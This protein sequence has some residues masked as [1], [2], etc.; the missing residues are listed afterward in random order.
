MADIS[1]TNLDSGGDSP[2]AARAQILEAVQRVNQLTGADGG[3]YVP[4][5]QAGTDAQVR[6]LLDK[7]RGAIL[8]LDDF[9]LSPAISETTALVKALAAAGVGG[10][11][12]GEVGRTYNIV[13]RVDIASRELRDVRLNLVGNSASL[14]LTGSA[15]LKH[16]VISVGSRSN[17]PLAVVLG[18]A[19]NL[20]LGNGIV[21]DDVEITDGGAGQIGI[22]C[23]TWANNTTI[24]NCRLNYIGWP[25]WFNDTSGYARVVDSINYDSVSLGKTLRVHN[26]ELGAADKTSRGDTL[27]VN[28]PA[29]RFADLEVIGC[30]S[31]KTVTLSPTDT[32]GLGIACANVDGVRFE[33]N[34][35]ENCGNNAG[36]LHVE[37]C[38]DFFIVNNRLTNN[39]YAI[40]IGVR[41][42]DGVVDKNILRTNRQGIFAAG[43]AAAALA[44][45]S[46]TRNHING[47]VNYPVMLYDFEDI[48][49]D[50]NFIDGHTSA[51]GKAAISMY[52]SGRPV[53][54]RISITNNWISDSY[55]TGCFPFAY[56]GTISEIQTEGNRYRNM[57]AAVVD[58][59]LRGV[60]NRGWSRD[61]HNAI[62]TAATSAMT[63]YVNGNPEG[64]IAGVLG[65]QVTNIETGIT[66]RH[67]GTFWAP[68]PHLLYGTSSTSFTVA[69]GA[70]VTRTVTV[71]GATTSHE[72]QCSFSLS[73]GALTMSAVFSAADT[74]TVT[75]TNSTGASIAIGGGTLRVWAINSST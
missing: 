75:I 38:T 61:L 9:Y 50:G 8:T 48:D 71:T 66:W 63:A 21:I 32:S 57:S 41:C 42:V 14:V 18:A 40:G 11:V 46:I 37:D 58:V 39:E 34:V 4:F 23:R 25:I 36:A 68:M 62:S 60:R 52:A 12:C 54:T 27:E 70:S 74:A 65:D 28:A 55:G 43:N 22:G 30:K 44:R 64:T 59:A 6:T 47:T 26:C 24:R 73:I 67:N 53:S 33:G 45:I 16:V 56:T 10:T 69:A 15:R 13:S 20:H 51:T 19:I 35:V 1:T 72:A 7:L 5:V 17:D 3:D 29:H 31:F 2:A 49:V